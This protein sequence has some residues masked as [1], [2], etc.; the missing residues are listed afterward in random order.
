MRPLPLL[1]MAAEDVRLAAHVDL[2]VLI[3]S[4]TRDRRD[5]YA[6]LVHLLGPRGTAPFVCLRLE[7][8]TGTDR[9]ARPAGTTMSEEHARRYIEAAHGGTLFV[10][11]IQWLTAGTRPLLA[12]LVESHVAR[13][14]DGCTGARDVRLITGCS[15]RLDPAED[16]ARLGPALYYRLNAIHIDLI[17]EHAADDLERAAPDI[18]WKPGA[19]LRG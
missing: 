5:L 10:D 3:T 16:I 6:R 18:R 4:D 11:D 19:G 13:Y 2:P 14:P 1:A 17:G 15:R 9:V 12:A 8:R 7:P